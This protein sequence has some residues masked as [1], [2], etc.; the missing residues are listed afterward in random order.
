M[1]PATMSHM[2]LLH[3]KQE[4]KKKPKQNENRGQV[5]KRVTE[6][7][8]FFPN[9]PHCDPY[10]SVTMKSLPKQMGLAKPCGT[11]C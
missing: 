10:N 5:A 11:P 6:Q 1:R 9:S 8:H 7:K 4:K 3:A 2:L